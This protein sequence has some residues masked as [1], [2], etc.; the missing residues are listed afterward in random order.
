[1]WIGPLALAV[2]ALFL[3]GPAYAVSPLIGGALIVVAGI[4][5]AWAG[6][7]GLGPKFR[8]RG[9]YDLA[10][11][12]RVHEQEEL[13]ALDP[14]AALG[15]VDSVLCLRCMNE[16]PARLGACPRCGVSC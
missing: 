12:Q 8:R 14:E 7:L 9:A 16:Y 13:R 1:M 3:A 11:L 4:S 10:E 6:V 15:D 2:G 5:A